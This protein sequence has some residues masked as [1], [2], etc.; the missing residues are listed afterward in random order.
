MIE[1]NN[2]SNESENHSKSIANSSVIANKTPQPTHFEELTTALPVKALEMSYPR[3][4]FLSTATTLTQ[5]NLQRSSAN[6]NKKVIGA[7]YS[8]YLKLY[9]IDENHQIQF[10]SDHKIV[11][12]DNINLRTLVWNHPA[13]KQE[14]IFFAHESTEPQNL[15]EFD[16]AGNGHVPDSLV[17]R[18]KFGHT[19]DYELVP[20][21]WGRVKS[22]FLGYSGHEARTGYEIRQSYKS[23]ERLYL[24]CVN[25]SEG[26]YDP[27]NPDKFFLAT[28]SKNHQNV[29]KSIMDLNQDFS[30][31]DSYHE[32][33]KKDSDGLCFDVQTHLDFQFHRKLYIEDFPLKT[34]HRY[35]FYA[36][37]DKQMLTVG[38]MDFRTRKIVNKSFLSVFKI[39]TELGFSRLFHCSTI[40]ISWMVYCI[41]LDTLYLTFYL[42]AKFLDEDDPTHVQFYEEENAKVGVEYDE[43]RVFF[44]R[45]DLLLRPY[46]FEMKVTNFRDVENREFSYSKVTDLNQWEPFDAENVQLVEENKE[47]VKIKLFNFKDGDETKS[48]RNQ[49]SNGEKGTK[50]ADEVNVVGNDGRKAKLR[51]NGLKSNFKALNPAETIEVSKSLLGDVKASMTTAVNAIPVD[52]NTFYLEDFKRQYIFDRGS[53]ELLSHHQFCQGFP[54]AENHV[55]G[56][57]DIIAT[58]TFT[59]GIIDIYRVTEN[60]EKDQKSSPH[61]SD[62]HLEHVDTLN[63]EVLPNFYLIDELY[64]VRKSSEHEIQLFLTVRLRTEENQRLIEKVVIVAEK[65]LQN[66]NISNSTDSKNPHNSENDPVIKNHPSLHSDLNIGWRLQPI[67]L[68]I[69]LLEDNHFGY[70]IGNDFYFTVNS[71]IDSAGFRVSIDSLST[72]STQNQKITKMWYSP[73]EEENEREILDHCYQNDLVYIHSEKVLIG[74]DEPQSKISLVKFDETNNEDGFRKDYSEVGELVLADGSEVLFYQK[75]QPIKIFCYTPGE[76]DL[77]DFEDYDEEGNDG[78]PDTLQ[79]PLLTIYDENLKA[80]LEIDFN[81]FELCLKNESKFRVLD[82]NLVF[83]V[84]KKSINDEFLTYVL[85]IDERSILR[86]T[87]FEGEPSDFGVVGWTGKRLILSDVS[88]FDYATR[89]KD[90]IFFSDSL[91]D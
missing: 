68:G 38:F 22:G 74:E 83:I 39:F 6:K 48:G 1:E 7:F 71:A 44:L 28:L 21:Y 76:E 45:E 62:L 32:R 42:R 53:G 50:E 87:N 52:K 37:V 40:C 31:L 46:H 77:S 17:F 15:L 84:A 25:D 49:V 19:K 69:S 12:P 66:S 80:L 70:V 56:D 57:K 47:I 34:D 3:D 9:E 58:V 4:K 55:K 27:E 88:G 73:D 79:T 8:Q 75:G 35:V 65:N 24:M 89:I 85:N 26:Y 86:V 20:E 5:N 10:I 18:C 90:S 14:I 2:N 36:R 13:P 30:K 16:E 91:V 60:T 64:C 11:F 63:L 54:Q 59:R 78:L 29:F 23:T 61:L 67:Q 72:D 43:P 41:E 81:G 51:G 33:L 82:G